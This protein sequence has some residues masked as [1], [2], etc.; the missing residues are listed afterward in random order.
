MGRAIRYDGKCF[1]IWAE[2]S[3]RAAVPCEPKEQEPGPQPD[4]GPQ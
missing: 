2:G 4:R 1:P 3:I